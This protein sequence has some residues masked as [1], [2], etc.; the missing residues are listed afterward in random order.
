MDSVNK[1]NISVNR[2]KNNRK[3]MSKNKIIEK[4]FN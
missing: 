3:L 4:V 1:R 2:N